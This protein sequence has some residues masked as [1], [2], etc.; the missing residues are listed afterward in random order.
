MKKAASILLLSLSFFIFNI[1]GTNAQ[2]PSSDYLSLFLKSKDSL[3]G[4]EASDYKKVKMEIFLEITKNDQIGLTEERIRTNCEL[5][6]RRMGLEPVSTGTDEFLAVG[7]DIFFNIMVVR[8]TFNRGVL[9]YGNERT[10]FSTATTWRGGYFGTH[11]NS[12]ERVL[13]TL[14]QAFDSFLNEYLKANQKQEK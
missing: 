8:L 7:V 3:N 14:A 13:N 5:R 10:Y 9:F 2:S 12:Q 6:L 11:G 4:L 1:Q